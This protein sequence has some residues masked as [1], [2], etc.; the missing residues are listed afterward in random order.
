M[1]ILRP[2]VEE[3]ILEPF[4]SS[5]II[6][7]TLQPPGEGDNVFERGF[8]QLDTD[9]QQGQVLSVAGYTEHE[10]GS[11]IFPGIVSIGMSTSIHDARGPPVVD[12]R[13]V[14]KILSFLPNQAV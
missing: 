5:T 10:T 12:L 1:S 9:Y 2:L 14:S 3:F 7:Y 8:I 4:Y 6:R 13:N 11:V